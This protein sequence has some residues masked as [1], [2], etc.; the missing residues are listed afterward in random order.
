MRH[1]K[2]ILI[3]QENKNDN[4]FLFNLCIELDNNEKLYK[5]IYLPLV[6][7]LVKKHKSGEFDINK[8]EQAMVIGVV[9][10]ACKKAVGDSNRPLTKESKKLLQKLIVAMLLKGIE[11][12]GET[13]T[14]EEEDYMVKWDYNNSEV[15][16]W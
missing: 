6:K 8:L 13:L 12:E 11:G 4:H 2:D 15:L 14:N 1:L 7:K 16:N 10:G 3:I 9:I 5:Q